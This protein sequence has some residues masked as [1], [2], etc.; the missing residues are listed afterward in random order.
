MALE[1]GVVPAERGIPLFH[2]CFLGNIRVTGRISE[3]ILMGAYKM[4]SRDLF[5]DLGLAVEMLRKG[6]I[7]LIPSVV[8]GRRMVRHI[9]RESKRQGGAAG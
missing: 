5:S 1:E 4:L 6:K 7:K 9:F 8:R 3:P 2:S